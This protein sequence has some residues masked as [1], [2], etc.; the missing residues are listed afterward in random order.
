VLAKFKKR[1]PVIGARRVFTT[2]SQEDFKR[3]I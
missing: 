2:F 1:W 3:Y